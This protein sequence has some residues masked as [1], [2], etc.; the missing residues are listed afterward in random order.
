M[1]RRRR[2]LGGAGGP[3]RGPSRR[4]PGP[5]GG[6]KRPL[7]GGPT[8]QGLW[9]GSG[10]P[11]LST[12]PPSSASGAA[13]WSCSLKRGLFRA[14]GGP[15]GQ[16]LGSA[17]GCVR[18][19]GAGL[20]RRPTAGASSTSRAPR[21]FAP[22]GQGLCAPG[23]ARRARPRP[24]PRAP[25]LPRGGGA[26]AVRA[27]RAPSAAAGGAAAGRG[28]PSPRACASRPRLRGKE[29]LERASPR[30]GARDRGRGAGGGAPGRSPER[31]RGA[32]RWVRGAKEGGPAAVGS[33]RRPR[34]PPPQRRACFPE[35]PAL[36]AGR[37]LQPPPAAGRRWP[38]PARDPRLPRPARRGPPRGGR[39]GGWSGRASAGVRAPGWP[40]RRVSRAPGSLSS[41]SDCVSVSCLCSWGGTA[42][43][44]RAPSGGGA[45]AR[46]GA[47]PH[48]VM[49]RP[50]NGKR[51]SRANREAAPA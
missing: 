22:S 9:E 13:A 8:L 15:H 28:A 20:R 16:G 45:S 44:G 25:G 29:A 46:L 47:H 7:R 11:K 1:V 42:N 34:S 50:T 51:R 49:A 6:A 10:P 24:Q 35:R 19:G 36:G 39:R 2:R 3:S 23:P 43:P 31:R 48:P 37:P 21:R 5:D 14:V 17:L 32:A 33:A 27:G 40:H 30:P 38:E 18:G 26:E 12:L 4:C 41:C